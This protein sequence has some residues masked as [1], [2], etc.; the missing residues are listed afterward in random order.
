[1]Y[2]YIIVKMLKIKDKR[3]ILKVARENDLSHT[4]K[5]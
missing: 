5:P 4:K 2:K 1:M 3:K